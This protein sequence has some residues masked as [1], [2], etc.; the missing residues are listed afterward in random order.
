MNIQL[1]RYSNVGKSISVASL[2]SAI[3]YAKCDAPKAEPQN[4]DK[5]RRFTPIQRCM[6]DM[7]MVPHARG[8]FINDNTRVSFWSKLVKATNSYS[9]EAYE[10]QMDF[11]PSYYYGNDGVF[12]IPL[13]AKPGTTMT[14][15]YTTNGGRLEDR[16]DN[17]AARRKRI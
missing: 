7:W 16:S 2:L 9:R 3:R 6:L 5:L 12:H 15:S 10:T 4:T 13:D 14:L 11:R 17:R 8:L 1:V